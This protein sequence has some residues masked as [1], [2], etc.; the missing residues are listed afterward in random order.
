MNKAV[1]L[2]RDGVINK[3]IGDYVYRKAD[4]AFNDG[5]FENLIR[6]QQQGY[7]LIVIT[8]QGGIAK[9]L[10]THADVAILHEY[11]TEM[12]SSKG[13]TITDIYYSPHHPDFGNSLS[14]KPESLLLERALARY[15]I[16]PALSY[17][18]GDNDRDIVAGEKAGVKGIKVSANANLSSIILP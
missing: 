11:M 13:I 6:F 3:E 17:F 10:Y 2:D 16:N 7:L 14:R 4:F 5:I 18:I 12:L 8:N 15:N 1:F 9:G